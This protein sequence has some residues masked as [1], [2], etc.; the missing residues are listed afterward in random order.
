MKSNRPNLKNKFKDAEGNPLRKN[1]LY[2]HPDLG[3]TVEFGCF[4]GEYY[5][6]GSNDFAKFDVAGHK[7]YLGF[8]PATI[9]DFIPINSELILSTYSSAL[10]A[11][12]DWFDK[13]LFLNSLE[14]AS[15]HVKSWP[16]V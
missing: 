3:G 9:K 13:Q 6:S 2:M 12:A 8:T 15:Q 14:R 10:R 1:Q 4:L 5:A 11:A 16:R 7:A